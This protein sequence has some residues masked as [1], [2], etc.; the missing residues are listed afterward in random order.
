MTISGETCSSVIR[1][2][3]QEAI[4]LSCQQKSDVWGLQEKITHQ[5]ELIKM[6]CSQLQKMTG[7]GKP[8]SL[9]LHCQGHLIFYFPY[10]I[11]ISL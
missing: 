4:M 7:L 6:L 2:D 5:N 9:N 3:L 11:I 1:D 10:G 8:S